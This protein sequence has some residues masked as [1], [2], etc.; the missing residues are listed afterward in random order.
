MF[1]RP[2][3]SDSNADGQLDMLV[4]ADLDRRA[5]QVDPRALFA[6]IRA[7]SP[8]LAADESI[9]DRPPMRLVGAAHPVRRV[10]KWMGGLSAAAAAIVVAFI[11][12]TQGTPA[13]ASPETILRDAQK[14]HQL[15]LDRCYL[16]EIK[17]ES[18]L[19][20]QSYPM[21]QKSRVTRLWTRGDRYW[22][23][24]VNMQQRFAWGRDEKGDLWIA[25]GTQRGLRFG[26][27][28]IPLWLKHSAEVYSMRI[29]HLLDEM[30]RDFDLTR[31]AA[32]AGQPSSTIVINAK[33]KPGR[34]HPALGGAR[35]E[36]DGETKVIRK[37][38]LDRTRMGEPIATVTYLLVDTQSQDAA[39]Y[40]L[41][42]QLEAPY[43]IFSSTDENQRRIWLGRFF[44]PMIQE[45]NLAPRRPGDVRPPLGP[46]GKPIPG[47]E[48]RPILSP[49]GRPL[50]QGLNRPQRP[51][52]DE[53]S[54]TRP[55][56]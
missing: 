44:G 8:A 19:L 9:A 4:R 5:D 17:K 23:E 42:G 15:P 11:L 13:Q 46:D 38:V 2:F 21:M 34:R 52:K 33:L 29:D 7:S 22:I 16:V 49:D 41:E 31:E 43:E 27:D 18:A 32:P 56:R 51:T 24:S 3:H 54:T 39:L 45:F 14:I 12:G 26:A 25:L 40:T 47:L 48:G 55:V 1:D 35:I 53:A 50:G 30:L 36:F 37:L 10:F 28:E 20:E 6:R